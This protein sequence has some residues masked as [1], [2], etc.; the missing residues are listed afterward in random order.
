MSNVKQFQNIVFTAAVCAITSITAQI[1]FNLGPIPYTMQN[2]GVI[3]AGLLLSP[4]YAAT[5]MIL[6][7]FLIFIGLPL[8]AGFTGGPS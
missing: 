3:L 6:Y 1:K 4:L 2:V 8:A 5:S 7:V